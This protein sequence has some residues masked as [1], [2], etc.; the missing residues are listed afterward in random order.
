ML[1]YYHTATPP[2]GYFRIDSCTTIHRHPPLFTSTTCR[3]N[4]IASG[5]YCQ[6]Q[7]QN[8]MKA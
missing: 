2:S 3:A 8:Y 5:G 7:Y 1:P 6:N 4:V